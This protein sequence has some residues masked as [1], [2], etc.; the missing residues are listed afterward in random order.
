MKLCVENP[1][2]LFWP[3]LY[4]FH[5]TT[6]VHACSP[7]QLPVLAL[8]RWAQEQYITLKNRF[9]KM[10]YHWLDDSKKNP[11]YITNTMQFTHCNIRTVMFIS[12]E[13][14]ALQWQYSNSDNQIPVFHASY[15]DC[16]VQWTSYT[17]L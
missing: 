17:K 5:G 8:K 7:V 1:G 4:L 2:L 16:I 14:D 13:Q 11:T 3:T 6:Y 9:E 12:N 15:Y 10:F